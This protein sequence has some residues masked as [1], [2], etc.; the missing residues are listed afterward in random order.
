PTVMA[1][2]E[3]VRKHPKQ[4]LD[5]LQPAL[6][7]ELGMMW[8]TVPFRPIYL[9]G[10][11]YLHAGDGQ[12]AAKEFQKII[13][14][15][16]VEPL[17]PYYPLAHLGLARVASDKEESRKKYDEFFSLWKEADPDIPILQQA[18]LEY[19]KL[20]L[21]PRFSISDRLLTEDDQSRSV[22]RF[23]FLGLE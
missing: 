19:E 10:Q 8:Q 2:A 9:R 16:G 5:T 20:R 3:L 15:R 17:S 22:V 11:A 12:N 13:D 4:A 14:H 21:T 1:R 18:K 7:Y 23:L 6:T